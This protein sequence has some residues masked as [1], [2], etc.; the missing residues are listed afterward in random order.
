M[1]IEQAASTNLLDQGVRQLIVADVDNGLF[2]HVHLGTPCGAFSPLRENPPGPRPLRSPEQV[3]G[4]TSGLTQAESKQLKEGN[5]HVVF[6]GDV[7]VTAHH[8]DV[9][10]ALE[11]PEPI[12]DV[13]I[14]NMPKIKL[15]AELKGVGS[16]DFDQCRFG[17]ETKKPARFLYFKVKRN[18][19]SGLRC[20]HPKKEWK[21]KDGRMSRDGKEEFA[22]KALGRYPTKLRKAMWTPKGQSWQGV[23]QP[24]SFPDHH[25]KAQGANPKFGTRQMKR[26]SEA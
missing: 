13:S 14:F 7:M 17:A 12:Q 6:S 16:V 23:C 26:P 4:L 11:N 3:E 9:S 25:T 8:A 22:S 2:D 20:N 19:L 18:R 15:V 24:R 21:D 1:D 5:E 10:F